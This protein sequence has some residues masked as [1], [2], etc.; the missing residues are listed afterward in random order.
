[1]QKFNI[2]QRFHSLVVGI[3]EPDEGYIFF[4]YHIHHHAEKRSGVDE[5]SLNT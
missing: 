3:A 5:K 1:M 4:Y 2:L